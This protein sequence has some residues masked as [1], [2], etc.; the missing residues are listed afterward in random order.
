MIYAVAVACFL[1]GL[2]VAKRPCSGFKKCELEDFCSCLGKECFYKKEC[3]RL[4][5]VLNELEDRGVVEYAGEFMGHKV[6]KAKVRSR[7]DGLPISAVWDDFFVKLD[8][9]L[10][11]MKTKQSEREEYE[12]AAGIKSKKK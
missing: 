6:F 2:L 12:K 7:Y 8:I 3:D 10:H 4:R 1:F 11:E 9:A 5:G